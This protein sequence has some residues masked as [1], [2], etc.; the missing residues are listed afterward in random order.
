MQN[1]ITIRVRGGKKLK[2]SVTPIPNKN[3]Y[4]A[5]LPA[6]LLTNEDITY[7]NVPA[8]SDVEKLLQILE[9]LGARVERVSDKKV[10]INCASVTSYKIDQKIGGEFRSSLMFAGP[11]LA[12]FGKAVIPMPGGCAL[13]LRGVEAH[14]DYF[15]KIGVSCIHRGNVMEFRI[16]KQPKKE[17]I[18]RPLESSVTATENLIMYAASSGQTIKLYDAAS[19]PHVIDLCNLLKDMGG[20]IE[21]VGSNRL[22]IS[23]NGG[24]LSGAS[25]FARPDHV[26]I[27]GYIVATAIT[28]GKITLKGANIP[29][30]VDT[31]LQWF[32]LF[33]IKIQR[34]E[35]DL[36][37]SRK[38]GDLRLNGNSGIFPMAAPNLP[39]IAPRPWP[40]FPADVIP[41]MATIACKTRGRL[42]LQNWMYEDA[43]QF[44]RELNTMG[45]DIFISSPQRI[46]IN[47]PIDF[48]GGDVTP[49]RVIQAMK[50]VFLAALADKAVTTIH[51]VEILK[52]RYPNILEVYQSLGADIQIVKNI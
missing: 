49:P 2:G 43:L 48:K 36:I 7:E 4:M 28:D 50:A 25:F 37:I 41:V 17:C 31:M 22:I 14:L 46:I 1:G 23:G 11:L 18:V 24:L 6:S 34:K 45:A 5:T 39:K 51:G 21:G 27:A 32:E 42:L 12:R 10:I 9:K 29:E 16:T 33:G 8:T 52:R 19:E 20:D 44:V 47:G 15:K 3:S 38:N 13:G 35:K 26:D 40:G 30:M